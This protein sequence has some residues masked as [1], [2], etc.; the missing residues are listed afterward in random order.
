MQQTLPYRV[1]LDDDVFAA[2]RRSLFARQWVAVA[3]ADDV[4]EPGDWRRI[5]VTGEQ[6]L[7]VRG[8]DRVLRAFANTCRHRG[9][10]LCPADGPV[11]GH[12]E[13]ALRCPYHHWTYALDGQLRAAPH[14]AETPADIELHAA[15]V[16]TWAGFV[17]VRLDPDESQLELQLATIDRRIRNY[18]LADLR[19]G[20]SVT[21]EVAA[22][23]KV[24]AE[25][26][27]ECYHCGPIHPEL[28][29]LVPA[30][31]HGGAD[32]PWEDG[33]AYRDGAWTL[34]TTGTT[35]RAPLAGLDAVEQTHHKGE[36]IYPNL[37]LSLSADHVVAFTLLPRAAGHTTI[38]CDFLFALDALEA[39]DFDPSDAV[40]LWDL[41]NRQDWRI[42]ESVQRGM[43]SF[44]A[45]RGWFAPMEDESADIRRWYLSIMGEAFDE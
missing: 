1:Y 33:I 8:A 40:E 26:Y 10:E 22:N 37:L 27:N 34:T 23:W 24:I 19:R 7:L 4:A 45:N 29:E 28:C 20:A 16:A 41:V 11:H 44:A 38:V 15:A 2:E 14:L 17:F 9:A 39:P 35:T 43:A 5:D 18:R 25:N 30:F 31:R 21:Y 12:V 6:L 32:L 36:L 42:A 13:R 3:R